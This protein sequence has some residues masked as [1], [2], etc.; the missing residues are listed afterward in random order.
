[1]QEPIAHCRLVNVARLRVVDPKR[2]ITAMPVCFIYKIAIKS[3]DV[4]HE[5]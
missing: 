2:S 4:V 1:M 3:K 5:T